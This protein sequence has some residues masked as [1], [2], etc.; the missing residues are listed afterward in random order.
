MKEGPAMLETRG[1]GP[2]EGAIKIG[3]RKRKKM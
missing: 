2:E 3:V 1:R